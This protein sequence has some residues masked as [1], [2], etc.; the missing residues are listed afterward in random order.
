MDAGPPR[1]PRF[2]AGSCRYA[3]CSRR[4]RRF[5]AFRC[6]DNRLTVVSVIDSACRLA[7]I[8]MG[9]RLATRAASIRPGCT[10]HA[11]DRCR[12]C[13]QRK[14]NRRTGAPFAQV[15]PPRVHLGQR[16]DQLSRSPGV[17]P[18]DQGLYRCGGTSQGIWEQ[19]R[20]ICC[21][22]PRSRC[23]IFADFLRLE[24]D[25]RNLRSKSSSVRP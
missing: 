23:G 19:V 6:G 14:A 13:V 1:L 20:E 16:G 24:D 4:S 2:R 8:A 22:R 7:E 21:G 12:T 18:H 15:K 3:T 11:R 17:R 5:S 9:N 10:P 25:A